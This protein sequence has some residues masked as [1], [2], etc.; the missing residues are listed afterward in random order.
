[1]PKQTL[2]VASSWPRLTPPW[3]TIWSLFYLCSRLPLYWWHTLSHREITHSQGREFLSLFG[4]RHTVSKEK[5]DS[6]HHHPHHF[7][8]QKQSIHYWPFNACVSVVSLSFSVTVLLLLLLWAK[9]CFVRLLWKRD[10]LIKS[11][12][13]RSCDSTTKPNYPTNRRFSQHELARQEV[14]NVRKGVVQQ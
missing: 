6:H 10:S 7:L 9:D 1:M 13:S 3:L 4:E 14:I 2:S 8:S 5:D 12:C 11:F